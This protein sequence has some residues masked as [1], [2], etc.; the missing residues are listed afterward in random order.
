M[1]RGLFI[2]V[3]V[4]VSTSVFADDLG[5]LFTTPEQRR[6]LD[7]LRYQEEIAHTQL[8]LESEE[9]SEPVTKQEPLAPIK[10][11]GLIY[12]KG[13]K[14]A[15]W[16]NDASTLQGDLGLQEIRVYADDISPDQVNIKLPGGGKTIQLRVGEKY[17]PGSGEKLDLTTE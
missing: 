2:A 7:A 11:K 8:Q 14:S 16:I 3:I 17:L 6:E 12:R 10:L 13:G 15:V 4:L 1:T 5:R 9:A